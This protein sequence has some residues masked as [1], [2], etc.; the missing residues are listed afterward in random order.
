MG[1]L[2]K[3]F[4]FKAF[5]AIMIVLVAVFFPKV[6]V[7]ARTRPDR[8][9]KV[10]KISE[11]VLR[12]KLGNWHSRVKISFPSGGWQ[13]DNRGRKLKTFG[14]NREF[15][16]SLP[17]NGRIQNLGKTLVFKSQK[18]L[19][20][21][22]GKDYRGFVVISI[23]KSGAKI[24]NHVGLEDYLRGVVGSEIGSRSPAESIKAQTVIARTYAYANRG[25]HGSEGAD[26]C[27]S[28]HCQVYKGV[29]AERPSIDPA[30]KGTRGIVM[31]SEG[32][33]VATLYH[34]TCGGMTSDNDKVFGGAPRSYLRRVA[35]PFCEK[36][37][38]YRWTRKIS[39]TDLKKALAKEKIFFK[40]LSGTEID[41]NEPMDR[42]KHV[43][44]LTDSGTKKIKGTTMRRLFNF[45]STTFVIGN[46]QMPDLKFATAI[47]GNRQNSS[48]NAG[49]VL[50]VSLNTDAD[51][52]PQQLFIQTCRGLKRTAR[53]EEGWKT[54]TAES[55]LPDSTTQREQKEKVF[56]AP[57]Q[58][59]GPLEHIEFFG[60]G[61]GH[62]VG[63]CQAGAIELGKRNWSYRQILAFYYS[64]VALRSLGY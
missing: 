2:E 19:I 31:I 56:T 48:R 49:K 32:D 8:N 15:T 54:I 10:T 60:R 47:A 14:N 61:F 9:D 37:T 39:I 26:V 12:V 44:L 38:Y 57:I 51:D 43:L 34:G 20:K 58:P 18:N 35:C 13:E 40:T 30:V 28:T 59:R 25:R 23:A 52:G 5:W 17:R 4:N 36:G 42:A 27:D 22:N 62:Q 1:K 16:W 50:I 6:F 46:R 41:A 24:I 53:P 29:A 33:P 55:F 63:L 7:D 3:H 21:I 64:N 45:P 11:P